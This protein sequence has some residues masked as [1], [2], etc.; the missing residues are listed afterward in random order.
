M[1]KVYIGIGSNIG[2]RP[3]N[4]KKA[5][6]YLTNIPA[7]KIKKVSSIYETSPVGPRQR[8]YINAAAQLET[9]LSPL[10]LLKELNKIESLMGR[11]KQK[12]RLMPRIIDLDILFYE[13]EIIKTRELTVPHKEIQNRRFVLEPLAEISPKFIHPVSKIT[14]AKMRNLL[15]PLCGQKVKIIK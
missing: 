10:M 12:K 6:Q 5:C 3:G 1:V 8:Y 7:C 13:D 9:E 2:N 14:V 11:E 15:S 4:I